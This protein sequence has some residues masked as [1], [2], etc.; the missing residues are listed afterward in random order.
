MT[1]GHV[2]RLA[3]LMRRATAVVNNAVNGML[4][5]LFNGHLPQ[6]GDG[7]RRTGHERH[8]H[9]PGGEGR[10]SHRE[11]ATCCRSGTIRSEARVGRRAPRTEKSIVVSRERRLAPA[12]LSKTTSGGGVGSRPGM[13]GRLGISR[14]GVSGLRCSDGVGRIGATCLSPWSEARR[15]GS[16]ASRSL[17]GPLRFAHNARTHT[18]WRRRSW[19]HLK[20]GVGRVLEVAHVRHPEVVVHLV[21]PR[22]GLCACDRMRP[23]GSR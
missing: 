3:L 21:G 20:R 11:L 2:E 23:H 5:S 18:K 22:G 8:V 1:G 14:S 15:A 10:P 16:S 19:K 12:E 17:P 7:R 4:R 13:L 6:C 9:I